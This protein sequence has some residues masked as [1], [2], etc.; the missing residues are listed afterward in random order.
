M[1]PRRVDEDRYDAWVFHEMSPLLFNV[2]RRTVSLVGWLNDME[3]IF[4]VC[5][6]KTHFSGS[7]S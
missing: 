5:H 1:D 7:A 3:T 4:P 2:T 6:I